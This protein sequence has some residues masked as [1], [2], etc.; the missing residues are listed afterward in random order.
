MACLSGMAAMGIDAVLPTFPA[1][2]DEFHLPQAEHNRIRQ[3]VFVFMLGFASLQLF[4]GILADV[5]GRKTMLISGLIIYIIACAAVYWVNDF[6]QLLWARFFQGAGLSAPRVLTM[7]IVRDRMSGAAMSR[8][9]SFVMMVFLMIPAV[10]PMIGQLVIMF[11]TW[12]SVFLLLLLFGLFLA[13]WVAWQLPETLPTEKRLPLN[14]AK[15]KQAI[16]VFMSSK[17]T[18]IYLLMMSLLFGM[19][20]T[21]VGLAEQ[22][23]QKDIYHLGERFPLYFALVIMG[24]LLASL[25]NAKFVMHWGMDKMVWIALSLLLLC[26]SL[27]FVS[28]LIGGGIIPLWLFIVL[29]MIHFLGFGLAMPNLNALCMQPFHQ[30]AGTA[31]ALIGTVTTILGIL[32]A[33]LIS[34]YFNATLYCLGIGYIVCTLLLW[35]SYLYL[36]KQK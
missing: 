31:S 19:L 36:A 13:L 7:T 29:L 2:I 18:Q 11:S 23:L 1:I 22:I 26:D 27:L 25:L 5:F 34:H 30:I 8:V 9:M 35:G 12:R 17:E 32:F 3:V 28:V 15:V 10:A 21:Y 6:E 14:L 4:F 24:M 20:M 16:S 33:Q